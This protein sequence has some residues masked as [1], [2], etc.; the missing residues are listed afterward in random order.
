MIEGSHVSTG[1]TIQAK[2]L[3]GICPKSIDGEVYRQLQDSVHELSQKSEVAFEL[4]G[5][6]EAHNQLELS[7]AMFCGQPPLYV[8]C[9]APKGEYFEEQIGYFGEQFVLFATS[10]GLGTCWVHGTYKKESAAYTRYP[11]C[12]LH[13]V[14]PVGYPLLPL[15]LKQKIIRAAIRKKDHKPE[16]LYKY[17]NQFDREEQ[18][19]QE[20]IKAVLAGPSAVNEQP[21][22]FSRDSWTN[23]ITAELPIINTG[24]EWCDLGIAKYHFEVAAKSH[25]VSGRWEWEAPA[26]FVIDS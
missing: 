10:L 3:S 21:V 25:G 5:P 18:W 9:V 20:G 24:M 2:L 16:E 22:V 19:V 8:T 12:T 26:R 7:R 23:Q 4:Q 15:P 6:F 11:N 1:S 14:I 13:D 17:P